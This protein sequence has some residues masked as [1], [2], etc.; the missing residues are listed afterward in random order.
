M[1]ATLLLLLKLSVAGLILAIG[2]GSTLRDL[3]YLWHQPGLLLRSLLE[4][5]SIARNRFG[6][7][8]V[9]LL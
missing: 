2:M 1:T 4:R 9:R 3:L 5:F 8:N 7:H 6:I